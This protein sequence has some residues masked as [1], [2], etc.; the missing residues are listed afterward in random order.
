MKTLFGTSNYGNE[1]RLTRGDAERCTHPGPCDE[2]VKDVMQKPYIKRQL[3]Q[4]S[5]E[6]LRKELSGYGAWSE[7]ELN[8]HE[9]NLM[10]WVWIS[11]G[12]IMEEL[13]TNY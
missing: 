8:D 2:D 11:A 6:Q 3:K 12:D 1:L 4:I 13:N 10:R 5:P 9:K 7:E